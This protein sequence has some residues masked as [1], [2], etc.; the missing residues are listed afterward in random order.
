MSV[1]AE[2]CQLIAFRKLHVL[3]RRR[4]QQQQLLHRFN[5]QLRGGLGQVLVINTTMG[6]VGAGVIIKHLDEVGAGD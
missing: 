3:L 2:D 1:S 6:W 4:L 5:P